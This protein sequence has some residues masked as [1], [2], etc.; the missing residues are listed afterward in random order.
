MYTGRESKMALNTKITKNKFSSL[1]GSLNKVLL[2]LCGLLV[3]EITV[4]TVLS[5]TYGI[6]FIDSK[7][8][9]PNSI[10]WIPLR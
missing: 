10:L 7:A 6:E 1:E 9:S 4:S 8:I 5:L 2:F 3:T